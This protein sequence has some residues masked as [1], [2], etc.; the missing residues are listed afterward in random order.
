MGLTSWLSA[1]ELS[2]NLLWPPARVWENLLRSHRSKTSGVQ[3]RGRQNLTPSRSRPLQAC[4]ESLVSL[5]VKFIS[6]IRTTF[7]RLFCWW[8]D[9]NGMWL[10]SAV[11][12]FTFIVISWDDPSSP[13]SLHVLSQGVL[14]QFSRFSSPLVSLYYYIAKSPLK[15]GPSTFLG[16][17]L[18]GGKMDWIS[19][20]Q[21]TWTSDIVL[22]KFVHVVLFSSLFFIFIKWSQVSKRRYFICWKKYL[23]TL[24]FFNHFWFWN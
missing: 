16:L 15:L 6:Q 21:F 13:D 9:W 14:V 19:G 7:A 11:L 18:P 23:C 8:N 12:F 10:S 24:W 3:W 20:T 1:N 4:S 2:Q 17:R 5:S 22:D